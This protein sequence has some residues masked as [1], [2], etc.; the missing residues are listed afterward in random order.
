MPRFTVVLFFLCFWGDFLSKYHKLSN[1]V[2]QVQTVV[3]SQ[4][5]TSPPNKTFEFSHKHCFFMQKL[6]PYLSTDAI[7]AISLPCSMLSHRISGKAAMCQYDHPTQ[8][9]DRMQDTC[10]YPCLAFPQFYTLYQLLS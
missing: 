6:H 9:F 7:K 10:M 5:S 2:S 3:R 1:A 4:I 8:L